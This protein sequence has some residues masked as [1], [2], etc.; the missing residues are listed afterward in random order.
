MLPGLQRHRQ[1]YLPRNPRSHRPASRLF[2]HVH[3]VR[4]G[5]RHVATERY[6]HTVGHLC[7][8]CQPCTCMPHRISIAVVSACSLST[9]THLCCIHTWSCT[10]L[11]PR[12]GPAKPARGRRRRL[13]WSC[14]TRHRPRR[15]WEPLSVHPAVVRPCRL[16]HCTCALPVACVYRMA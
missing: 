14:T 13:Q 9:C 15:R 3:H 10:H 11:R 12:C 1:C 16:C 5:E 4:V 2:M 8:S 7:C 6:P